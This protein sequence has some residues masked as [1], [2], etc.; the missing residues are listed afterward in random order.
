MPQLT[1]KDEDLNQLKKFELKCK[2]C[3]STRCEVEVDWAA[4]PSAS[5]NT[6]KVICKDCHEDETVYESN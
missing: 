5:W 6:T 3:G 2:N 1:L 4:Y